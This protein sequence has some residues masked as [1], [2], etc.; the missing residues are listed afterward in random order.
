MS[1]TG[2]SPGVIAPQPFYGRRGMGRMGLIWGMIGGVF[3][4][5]LVLLIL[6]H[7]DT[8]N[9]ALDTGQCLLTK[10]GPGVATTL[11]HTVRLCYRWMFNACG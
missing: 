10:T 5:G 4:T 7:R 9:N 8:M 11:K 6:H 3:L 2:K 1:F